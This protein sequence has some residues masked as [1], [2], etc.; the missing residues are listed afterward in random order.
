MR[1]RKRLG[2][3]VG[4]V[5]MVVLMTVAAIRP[6]RYADIPLVASLKPGSIHFAPA[7]SN[8]P[9][10]HILRVYSLHMTYDDAVRQVSS[11]VPSDWI[12]LPSYFVCQFVSGGQRDEWV[13]VQRGRMIVTPYASSAGRTIKLPWPPYP[14]SH[15]WVTVTTYQRLST[16]DSL[17]EKVRKYFVHGDRDTPYAIITPLPK[18]G[19]P[20]Q[21]VDVSKGTMQMEGSGTMTATSGY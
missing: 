9:A 7:G 4:V 6:R 3:A 11:Q 8:V 21:R 10:D 15:G 19:S 5:L 20:D 16:Y 1:N 12:R 2:I 14:D 18:V 17:R 13:F